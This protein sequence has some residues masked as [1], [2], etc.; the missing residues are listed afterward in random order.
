MLR[1]SFLTG[2]FSLALISPTFA[3]DRPVWIIGD[4]I[5]VGLALV[6][7]HKSAAVVGT[8]ASNTKEMLKQIAKVP[9]GA[10]VVISL[11]TNDAYGS[12]KISKAKIDAILNALKA[13]N[14]QYLWVGPPDLPHKTVASIRLD[15]YLSSTVPNYLD[16]Y[17]TSK[18]LSKYRASDG[19]HFSAEGYRKLWTFIKGH[20]S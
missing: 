5:G 4:S 18:A 10:S 13:K 11:G 7:G 8:F 1:R 19:I 14:C 17:F 20:I 6:S 12:G 15:T 9:S 16:I 2:L 3:S